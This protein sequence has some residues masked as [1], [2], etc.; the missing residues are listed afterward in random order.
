MVTSTGFHPLPLTTETDSRYTA[1]ATRRTG[2]GYTAAYPTFVV[3]AGPMSR[4]TDEAVSVESAITGG[5]EH[6][7]RVDRQLHLAVVARHRSVLLVLRRGQPSARLSVK[8]SNI[9][10]HFRTVVGLIIVRAYTSELTYNQHGC[11][12]TERSSH[13]DNYT[14]TYKYEVKHV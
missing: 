10:T 2:P 14:I 6:G 8:V 13:L 7:A 9:S 11:R 12:C 3:E 5:D 4:Q 1:Q